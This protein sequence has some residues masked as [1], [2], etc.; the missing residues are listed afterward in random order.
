MMSLPGEV[1]STGL[2]LPESLT[3][4]RWLAVGEELK[5]AERSVRWWLG[6]WIRFGERK[7]GE[8]YS[9]GMD[10]TGL[11]YQDLADAKYVADKYEFS[12]RSENLSW[13][14]HRMAAGLPIEQR[15]E[16]L[17]RAAAEELSVREVRAEVSRIR[18]RVA[19]PA[20]ENT[21]AV[22]DL[23][24]LVGRKFSTI[25]ADP[26]WLYGNQGTRAAT[27]KH[28]KGMTVDEI[29]VLPISTLAAD[30]AHLHLWTTNAF[31][32]DAKR[33][34]EAWGFE[35]KS[36]Y[37]WVKP[38]IGIG[39]YW[40]V[41]HEFLLLGVRGSA[42]FLD[43]GQKSWGEFDRGEHSQKPERVRQ[44]I[45]RVS[46]APRLELFGRRNVDGW[47]VWGNQIE[48]A[49]FDRALEAA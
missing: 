14:H 34:M 37:V 13:T 21:C 47:T 38:S 8:T 22:D 35:Y 41:S 23:A 43:R 39:N 15:R 25:Y 29:C 33:V 4:E 27:S 42:P 6:D 3:I 45:E 11:T 28:Y 46:L 49:I 10:A 30:N 18:N 19:A 2:V 40:R 48:R 5:S 26:P 7:Y 32:F 31:L 12:D 9:Q 20:N 24:K 17:A 36:V 44:I 16:L 1:T